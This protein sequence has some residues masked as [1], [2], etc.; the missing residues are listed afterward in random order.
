MTLAAA[1]VASLV[2]DV[3]DPDSGTV[4]RPGPETVRPDARDRMP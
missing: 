1:S 2:L 4:P 3:S